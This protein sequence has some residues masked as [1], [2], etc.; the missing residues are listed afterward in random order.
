M[1]T[2]HSPADHRYTLETGFE[3]DD[4]PLCMTG[5]ASEDPHVHPIGIGLMVAHKYESV[6]K[7]DLG[8]QSSLSVS[9]DEIRYGGWG[10]GGDDEG[11]RGEEHGNHDDS[12]IS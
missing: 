7:V 3:Q 8:H 12:V 11:C 1:V 2:Y 9:L 10:I 6:G 5:I 4:D